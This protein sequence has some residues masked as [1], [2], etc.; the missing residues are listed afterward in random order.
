MDRGARPFLVLDGEKRLN[1]II[2]AA[3]H[4][5]ALV[6]SPEA[7]EGL[8]TRAKTYSLGGWRS[9]HL[10]KLGGVGA[11]TGVAGGPIGLALEGFD[12]A[13]LLAAAGRACYG[14][15]HIK[16]REVDYE[17]DLA[18][19]L[20]IWCGAA[21]AGTC[22]ATGK[23]GIKIAGKA[24][25]GMGANVA[26]KLAGKLAAKGALKL[27]TKAGAKIVAWTASKLALKIASKLSVKWIPFIGGAVSAGIN[28]WIIGGLMDA[29]EAYYS[30]EYVILGDDLATAVD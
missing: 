21:E 8:K 18:L 20:A 14:I 1:D 2:A 16:D 19:I 23:V 28:V 26:S 29:A 6:G 22:I 30:H 25:I 3:I 10:A 17:S 13:Y 4:K 7:K 15:G 11:M 12:I 5:M 27:G 24:A 9:V